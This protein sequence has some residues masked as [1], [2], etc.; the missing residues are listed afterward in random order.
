MFT[1]ERLV[2]LEAPAA[3]GPEATQDAWSK[4]DLTNA[5]F[6]GDGAARYIAGAPAPPLLAGAIGRMAAVS[7]ARGLTVSPAALHPLYV[8]RPDVELARD[9]A[10]AKAT[11]TQADVDR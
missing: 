10:S 8:R 6:T 1:P 11:A 5:V 4:H 9:T 3:A 7:A 2:E